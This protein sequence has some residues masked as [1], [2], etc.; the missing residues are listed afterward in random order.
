MLSRTSYRALM[1]SVLVEDLSYLMFVFHV[2]IDNC[3]TF[4]LVYN[5]LLTY[6]WEFFGHFH[7]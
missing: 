5:L 7:S 4:W 3:F 1:V 6:V 2:S